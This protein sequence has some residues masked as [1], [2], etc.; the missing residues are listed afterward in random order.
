M[1]TILEDNYNIFLGLYTAFS[2]TKSSARVVYF[3]ILEAQRQYFLNL[4]ETIEPELHEET[5]D[6]LDD[7]MHKFYLGAYS[8]EQ[9]WGVHHYLE[10][11][12]R[13]L[14]DLYDSDT[15]SQHNEMTFLLSALLD[16]ALYSWRS[17]LD[18]YLK[19]LLYFL[20]G[21][22]IVTMSTKDFRKGITKFIEENQDDKRVREI[23]GYI[24]TKVLSQTFGE[25]D[26]SW[27]DLLKSLRDKTTH[28]KLIKPTIIEQPNQQGY[29]ISWPTIGGRNY[30]E[31]A[32]WEFE[33]NAF[34]MLRELFPILYG[35]DWISGPYIEGMFESS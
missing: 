23:E 1:G 28:Q 16:Q 5:M 4:G 6:L 32:Q 2:R 7:A 15:T 35:F 25:E 13:G 11:A 17:F 21:E 29:T 10:V 34:E 19:Y 26:E 14:P 30:S 31:L 8:L 18:Y 24:R 27:G 9:L 22:Y 20:T 33:N 12:D 3:K